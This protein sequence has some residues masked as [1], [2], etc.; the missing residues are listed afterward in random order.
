M[1]KAEDA[2]PNRSLTWEVEPS[3]ART[4]TWQ[5]ISITCW[6]FLSW[7]TCIVVAPCSVVGILGS[8]SSCGWSIWSH[9][10][11]AFDIYCTSECMDID[12]RNAL[13]SSNWGRVCFPSPILTF[14]CERIPW[15]PC[16]HTEDAW[17]TCKLCK[18]LP[19]WPCKRASRKFF[20]QELLL[21]A[22][23]HFCE[24]CF[25][26]LGH[27]HPGTLIESHKEEPLCYCGFS[28]AKQT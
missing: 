10:V 23:A 26:S 4:R 1:N 27:V 19:C 21:N 22:L 13:A 15:I 16:I 18:F 2:E 9:D 25:L 14:C 20:L 3:E 11:V 12:F 7:G 17:P 24:H 28:L 6:Q 8:F 5:V